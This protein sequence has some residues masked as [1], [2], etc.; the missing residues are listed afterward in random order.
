MDGRGCEVCRLE[1]G[2]DEDCGDD[3]VGQL[4]HQAP[5]EAA[6]RRKTRRGKWSVDQF[7]MLLVRCE[8]LERV[9]QDLV[10]GHEEVLRAQEGEAVQVQELAI[11][12][13]F[14]KVPRI[15]AET[16]TDNQDAAD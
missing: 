13:L 7:R 5:G 3:V 15:T 4:V 6:A 2:A 11:P 16:R 12:S 14:V 9:L 1:G 8:L 10:I